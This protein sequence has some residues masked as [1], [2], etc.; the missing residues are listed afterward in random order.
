MP[1]YSNE[2]TRETEKQ[3]GPFKYQEDDQ[4]SVESDLVTRGAYE[5]DNGGVYVG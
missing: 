5:L 4:D 2:A 1:D 3:I